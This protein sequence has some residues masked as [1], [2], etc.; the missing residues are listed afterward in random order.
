MLYTTVSVRASE[1][2]KLTVYTNLHVLY[3]SADAPQCSLDFGFM[4]GSASSS[5]GSKR[6]VTTRGMHAPMAMMTLGGSFFPA[7]ASR[8][9]S[10]S[11]V[12]CMYAC[13][14]KRHGSLS[15][16]CDAYPLVEK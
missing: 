15:L 11:D 14:Q 8:L 12:A 2:Q 5:S 7:V 16:R 4:G 3:P 9:H 13:F 10:D 1:D 6:E